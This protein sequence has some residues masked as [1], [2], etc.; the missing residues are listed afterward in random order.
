MADIVSP[1]VRSRMMAGIRSSGTKPET[2]LGHALHAR[3][4]RY[5]KNVSVLP[6]K[7][8]LVFA[9]YRAVVF[10]NGC[11]WH[12]HECHLFKWP[13]TRPEFWREKIEGNRARDERRTT[14]LRNLGWRVGKVW[15]CSLKGKTRASLDD[16]A[17]EC[18][19]WIKGQEEFLEVRGS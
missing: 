9:R 18:V 13:S 2:L 3:G 17:E 7:P 11:F 16:I 15:E 19:G 12:G 14:E 4:L 1:Q 10:V 6:G 8:D 5:R